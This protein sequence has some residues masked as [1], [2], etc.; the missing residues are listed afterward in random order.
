MWAVFAWFRIGHCMFWC[1][2]KW[3]FELACRKREKFDCNLDIPL[4]YYWGSVN[5]NTLANYI[6]YKVLHIIYINNIE[7]NKNTET[8]HEGR[9][10]TYHTRK[11]EATISARS[12]PQ[13]RKN[14]QAIRS[15]RLTRTQNTTSVLDKTRITINQTKV[16]R[17]QKTP[18]RPAIGPTWTFLMD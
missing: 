3:K 18:L 6:Y 9:P 2:Q 16:S 5:N 7:L 12:T 8:T 4:W 10:S 1:S 15:G 17:S 14:T 11:P 13:R